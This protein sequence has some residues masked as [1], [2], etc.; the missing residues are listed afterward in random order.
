MLRIHNIKI[1]EN[2]SDIELINFICKKYKIKNS[3]IISWKIFKKSI[4]ARKKTDIF[5][6][7]TIDIS[8]NDESKY[9]KFQ[10]ID[11]CNID[12]TIIKN[13]TSND[14]SKKISPVIIGVCIAVVDIF[15]PTFL[16]YSFLAHIKL[17]FKSC[18]GL[19]LKYI[20]TCLSL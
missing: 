1:K 6:N 18:S 15:Y 8:V 19:K 7:Y 13:F 20:S 3:D 16:S 2:F 17:L 14:I 11:D 5:F 10:K 12:T 4:D 9:T